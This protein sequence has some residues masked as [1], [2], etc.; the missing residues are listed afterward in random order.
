MCTQVGFGSQ[1]IVSREDGSGDMR[2]KIIYSELYTIDENI[3]FAKMELGIIVA[4]RE[5]ELKQNNKL[6]EIDPGLFSRIYSSQTLT[7]ALRYIWGK[8]QGAL[9]QLSLESCD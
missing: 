3:T 6:A 7:V 2:A 9:V 8:G 1:L 4:L 5:L